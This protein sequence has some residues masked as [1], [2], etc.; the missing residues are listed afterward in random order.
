MSNKE[1]LKLATKRLALSWEF[2]KDTFAEIAD[3]FSSLF[4]KF[5]KITKQ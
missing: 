4:N 1:Q 2:L 5:F 3:L